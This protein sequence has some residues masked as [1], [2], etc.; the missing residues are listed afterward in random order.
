MLAATTAWSQNL[1]YNGDM[2]A[3]PLFD[4]WVLSTNVLQFGGLVQGS[5]RSAVLQ[6]QGQRIG[7]NP[8]FAAPDWYLDF[9]FAIRDA[10]ANRAFSLLIN[11]AAGA[12]NTGAATINLRYQTAQFNTFAAGTWGTDLG[13]GTIQV[14][15]DA[16][17][18]GD[19]DDA[20][21]SK[22][23]YRMRLTGHSWGM[24][25]ANYDIELSEPNSTNLTRRV[26]GLTRY[27]TSSGVNGP[28]QSFVFNTAFG[29][30]PGF[31]V[32]DV[33][34]GIIELPD[35]P[36]LEVSLTGELF[37]RLPVDSGSVQRALTIQNSGFTQDLVI[38]NGVI[39]GADASRYSLLT[40][41]PVYIPPG[42]STNLDIQ[43]DPGDGSRSFAASL[44]LI[45]NDPSTP[46]FNVNLSAVRL[47]TGAQAF[48]NSDFEATPFA[49][50]WLSS[51]GLVR[52]AGL[53]Q[54]STT[55][56]WLS[57]NGVLLGQ[58]AIS[59]GDWHMDFHFA[60]TN[61]GES[62]ADTFGLYVTTVGDVF[63]TG[64]IKLRLRYLTNSWVV[65]GIERPELGTLLPSIDA[66]QDG[67]LND[68]NDVKNVYRM[69]IVGRAWDTSTATV[70][71]Q[72]SDANATAFT[73]GLLDVPLNTG[74]AVPYGFAFTSAMNDN[75]GFWVDDARLFIGVPS[76]RITH[77][78]LP[79][80]ST[81]QLR[82]ESVPNATYF[83]DTSTNLSMPW[84]MGAYGPV[85]SEGSSTGLTNSTSGNQMFF[86]VR[87]QQ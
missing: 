78:L 69:R 9:Y 10:G 38:T 39:N 53:A 52:V 28:P 45:S 49:T 68:P 21:D 13:L 34:F 59:S 14:S 79:S 51:T 50:G 64:E 32:D 11:Q 72:L 71:I 74:S 29:S 82:W 66:N 46:S 47:M 67:D 12:E 36:N 55:A 87:Q 27:Q 40:P 57:T 54:A 3:D 8:P 86:R 85:L 56:A 84:T 37:G 70:D 62:L 61:V 65:L 17:A 2:E 16:N 5:T 75:P 25:A 77:L 60:I 4:G 15:N 83:I 48:Q 81:F 33:E 19:L 42:G 6:G 43:F 63:N 18:D 22:F 44:Q 20:G 58:N 73:R 7:Q 1:L 76:L 26:N 35:D 23:V 30:N 31:W 41:L 24:P 80:N